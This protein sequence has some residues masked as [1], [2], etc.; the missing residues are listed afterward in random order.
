MSNLLQNDLVKPVSNVHQK[1]FFY[2]VSQNNIHSSQVPTFLEIQTEN[3]N[4]YMKENG[5]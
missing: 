1:F 5:M 4:W 3:E 2:N